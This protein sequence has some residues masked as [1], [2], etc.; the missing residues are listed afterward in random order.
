VHTIELPP[1]VAT[2]PAFAV[3]SCGAS[4]YTPRGSPKLG[5]ATTAAAGGAI[6]GN[7]K[8]GADS[9]GSGGFASGSCGKRAPLA[10]L[11]LPVAMGPPQEP[12]TPRQ[13]PANRLAA[14]FGATPP[15]TPPD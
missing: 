8:G 2:V 9:N 12:P 7:G 5:A 3:A 1:K 10:A 11:Q 6:D 14:A 15:T 13:P 4:N